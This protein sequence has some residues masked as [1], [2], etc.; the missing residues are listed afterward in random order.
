MRTVPVRRPGVLRVTA[1]MHCC[2][3]VK[4]QSDIAQSFFQPSRSHVSMLDLAD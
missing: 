3:A 1:A 2:G 4:I